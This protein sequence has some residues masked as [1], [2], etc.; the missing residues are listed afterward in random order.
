ML[1]LATYSDVCVYACI[2]IYICIIIV[3]VIII[4]LTLIMTVIMVILMPLSCFN[5]HR[6]RACQE[7]DPRDSC[8]CYT[9]LSE[10]WLESV[11]CLKDRVCLGRHYPYSCRFW[12]RH[13]REAHAVTEIRHV[14]TRRG[15]GREFE[16]R[17]HCYTFIYTAIYIYVCMYVYIYIYFSLSLSVRA[18]VCVCVRAWL[19]ACDSRDAVGHVNPDP[20]PAKHRKGWFPHFFGLRGRMHW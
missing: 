9:L 6:N 4:I 2:Y 10:S 13:V 18:F 19:L 7:R 15:A 5:C 11:H 20:A 3:V 8:I 1:D 14:W 16:N 12:S 17:D